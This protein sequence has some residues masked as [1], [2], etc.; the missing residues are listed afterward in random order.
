MVERTENQNSVKFQI[1]TTGIN[2][3]PEIYGSDMRELDA[4]QTTRLFFPWINRL[5]A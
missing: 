2:K 3:T 4:H 1:I 5:E